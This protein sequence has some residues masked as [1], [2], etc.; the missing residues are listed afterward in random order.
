M[1]RAAGTAL[2]RPAPIAGP[3]S[4][5]SRAGLLT[6]APAP[7]RAAAPARSIQTATSRKRQSLAAGLRKPLPAP[8]CARCISTTPSAPH[9]ATEPGNPPASSSASSSS[10]STDSD[11][12]GPTARYDALVHK[13]IL[14][15]D[16]FQRHIIAKLQV[17]HDSLR[18][19][20]QKP[21]SPPSVSSA[22]LASAAARGSDRAV[23][24]EAVVAA[25]KPSIG[26]I[27]RS[28]FG[29]RRRRKAGEGGEEDDGPP[30]L[31]SLEG[32]NVPQG[33]YLYGDVGTGKSM[34]M[35]LF[36]DTL[37]S[38]IK[39]KRR[40]HFHQFMIDVHKRSHYFKS[41]YHRPSGMV[42]SAATAG[43]AMVSKAVGGSGEVPGGGGGEID[44]I[45]PVAREIA[46]ECEVL[47]F[48]EFQ[49]TDI[50]DAMILRRL[51]EQIIAYGVVCVMTSK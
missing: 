8:S 45:E 32:K 35:D 44:P 34:L 47:C 20:A 25:A 30:T 9:P 48:D 38:N 51:L 40:I 15:D 3:S 12:E 18:T 46:N 39:R 1:L 24:V 14:T 49:V 5:S 2:A 33:M 22:R 4:A 43:A 29:G 26:G 11:G 6:K 19:Y 17:L 16:A 41:L 36:F 13:G 37:P 31:A 27:F 50:A 28:L 21:P 7:A 10:T 23:G 42:M